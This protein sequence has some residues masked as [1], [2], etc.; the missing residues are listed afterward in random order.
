MII[1]HPESVGT[2]AT[3]PRG[4]EVGVGPPGVGVGVERG[5]GVGVGGGGREAHPPI[6][7]PPAPAMVTAPVG[8]VPAMVLPVTLEPDPMVMLASAK[9]FPRKVIPFRVAEVPIRQNTLHGSAVP[10]TLEPT[11][12]VSPLSTWKTNTPGPLR[13]RVPRAARSAAPPVKE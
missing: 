11:F 5:V 8:P 4:V 3:P 7:L 6:V 12:A 1:P 2:G 9:T 13:V 10:T